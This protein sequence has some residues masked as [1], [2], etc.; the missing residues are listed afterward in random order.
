MRLK[1][2]ERAVMEER[3]SF[4]KETQLKCVENVRGLTTLRGVGFRIG[5]DKLSGWMRVCM[6]NL[7]I[8]WLSLQRREKHID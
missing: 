5:S 8:I 4:F 2:K 3:G 1:Q 7:F 6:L